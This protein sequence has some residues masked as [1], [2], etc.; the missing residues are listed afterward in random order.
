MGILRVIN[1]TTEEL[2][3]LLEEHTAL[4]VTSMLHKARHEYRWPALSMDER[5]RFIRRLMELL[6]QEKEQLARIMAGEIG[7]PLTAGRHEVEL[8]C[9]RLEAYCDLFPS[10]LADETL[11]EN[12][13][14]K[15]IARYEPLGI[16]AV[17]APWNAPVFISLASLI[18][19]L[20]CGNVVLYKPSEYASFTGK[21]LAELFE[22]LKKE[23]MPQHAFQLVLGGKDVGQYLVSSEIDGVSLTGS[24]HAGQEVMRASAEHLHHC[25][26]EL[27]GKDPAIVIE[28]ANLEHAA[29]EIVRAAT[30]YTGQVCFG[31]ERV[32]CLPEVYE[33]FVE[34]CVQEVK[35]LKV[36][37]PLDETTNI[38]PFSVKFQMERYLAHFDEALR[39]GARIAY[40]GTRLPRRGFF[41][42]PGVLTQVTH[43]MLIMREETFGPIIPIMRVATETEAIALA[44]DSDYGLTASIWTRNLAR[45]EELARKLQAGTVSINRHGMSKPGC[46][47]GGFKKSGLGRIYSKEGIR[48]AFTNIKHVWVVK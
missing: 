9:K 32:Y 47:W 4:E 16:V 43:E 24:V 7:K 31:V 17:I 42:Q 23:G 33:R 29:K 44:N 39:M 10:W 34:L 22:I 11:F 18:P 45:G 48:A 13:R 6:Q 28:D 15:N 3:G 46:P 8:A 37:D 19:P 40:G 27:G 14:E 1:P 2:Y 35:A 25:V 21:A 36:G 41:V 30:M 26:L 38:G 20:L 5:I 12:D